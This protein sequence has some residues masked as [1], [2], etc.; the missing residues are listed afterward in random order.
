MLQLYWMIETFIK[1]DYYIS[2]FDSRLRNSA[3][4]IAG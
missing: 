4:I 3:S 1:S 2:V